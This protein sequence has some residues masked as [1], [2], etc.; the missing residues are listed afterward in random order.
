MEYEA[1]EFACYAEDTTP[2]TYEQN[3]D[4]TIE[5]PEIDM[6]K[7]NEWSRNNGF[8]ANQTPI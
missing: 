1:T 6:S 7:N 2:Y 3:F 5:N 4:E 8:K